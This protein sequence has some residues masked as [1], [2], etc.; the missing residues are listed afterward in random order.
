MPPLIFNEGECQQF[1]Q[2]RGPNNVRSTKAIY[3]H[4][5]RAFWLPPNIKRRLKFVVFTS[6]VCSSEN[7]QPRARL[8]M[9]AVREKNSRVT[10]RHRSELKLT[11]TCRALFLHRQFRTVTRTQQGNVCIKLGA[12]ESEG[13]RRKMY[14]GYGNEPFSTF[15]RGQFPSNVLFGNLQQVRSKKVLVDKD[16]TSSRELSKLLLLP[17]NQTGKDHANHAISHI[18]L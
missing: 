17:E 15:R 7:R 11:H 1:L 8:I 18:T 16:S 9:A 2:H 12:P 5:H 4:M 13:K 3:A 10:F 6:T 14:Q